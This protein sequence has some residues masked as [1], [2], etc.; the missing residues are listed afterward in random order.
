MKKENID[1]L[2]KD[3][4]YIVHMGKLWGVKS[5]HLRKSSKL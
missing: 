5:E 1:K 4:S 3:I 2:T